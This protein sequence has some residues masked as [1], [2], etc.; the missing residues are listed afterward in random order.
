MSVLESID[1]LHLFTRV[2][3]WRHS[4]CSARRMYLLID[5]CLAVLGVEIS[6]V[7]KRH[8]RTRPIAFCRC[9]AS[10][11][12]VRGCSKGCSVQLYDHTKTKRL[13]YG[14]WNPSAVNSTPVATRERSP[15]PVNDHGQW[16]CHY[17][18]FSRT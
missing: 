14:D 12:P 4:V 15:I 9:S 5:I 8:S 18:F 16:M 13:L 3:T 11:L 7:S 2:S 1:S 6:P 17:Y 10:Q